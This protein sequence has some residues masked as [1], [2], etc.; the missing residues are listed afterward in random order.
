E[1][2]ADGDA[3]D[4]AAELVIPGEEVAQSV[5]QAEHPLAYGDVREDVINEVCRLLRDAAAGAAWTEA[6]SFAREGHEPLEGTVLAPNACKTS[7]DRAAGQ[8]LPE[9]ALDEPGEAATL[10]VIS[11]LPQEGF[12]VLA[13]DAM[14]DGA[15][16][17]SGLIRGNAHGRGA[18]EARAVPTSAPRRRSRPGPPGAAQRRSETPR[19]DQNQRRA[20]RAAGPCARR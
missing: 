15:L 18:S 11:D 12:Q 10:A 3:E 13:D 9:L 19:C 17:C 20:G 8:E 7:A 14:E 5:G 6:P 4:L 2:G 1:H 16:R